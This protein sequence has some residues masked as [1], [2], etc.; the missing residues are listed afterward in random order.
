MAG[1]QQMLDPTVAADLARL[2][3]DLSHNPKTRK[4][5]GK[6]VREVKPD[7]SHARAFSDIDL[8][9]RM[10]EFERK[11]EEKETK[12]A[13]DAVLQR[14]N[15]QRSDLL[16]GGADGSGRKYSED[17]VKNIET[18]MQ[19]KG[20]VNY[21]DG[22]I[23][24]AATLP[25]ENGKPSNMPPVHGSTW[26]FP[27]WNKFSGDPTRAAREVAHDVIGEFMRKR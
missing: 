7:S 26:E 16:S 2:A 5:F 12:R 11:Q 6:L 1:E 13:Q 21:D 8:D 23:L 22:A 15:A 20:I 14:M 25:P 24:Y 4:Q 27:E 10:S 17:D 18:L 19:S 3:L 9:D